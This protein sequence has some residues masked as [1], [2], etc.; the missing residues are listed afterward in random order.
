MQS[1]GP[2]LRMTQILGVLTR[3]SV[4]LAADRRLTEIGTG[5]VV[6]DDT[7]KIVSLCNA[8]GIAYTGL[9]RLD[10][11]P[12]HEWICHR[13]ADAVVRRAAE[14]IPVITESATQSFMKLPTRNLYPHTFL[15]AGYESFLHA[16]VKP[17]F[18]LITNMR[19]S[20]GETLQS[21]APT[22]IAFQFVL[23]A[24]QRIH[25]VAAGARL[26][27]SRHAALVRNMG[28]A[29]SRNTS[30]EALL[31]LMTETIVQTS[32]RPT[33]AVGERVLTMSIPKDS[34]DPTS[35]MSV[36]L[37]APATTDAATFGYLVPGASRVLQYGPSF[38]CG[39]HAV[40]DIV[41][42]DDPSRDLQSVSVRI[43][44]LPKRLD[45]HGERIAATDGA[46]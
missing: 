23:P 8:A 28:R 25:S 32:R 37:A 10:G 33:M 40:T 19:N 44:R 43:L 46:D 45:G 11:I 20:S 34:V 27:S 29:Y 5:R 9:A 18:A 36:M 42:Q 13:L 6:H 39:D 17:M 41:T 14:A 22:F 31:R 3:R 16:G 15:L 21:P 26:S 35:R 30:D 1:L 2:E 24:Q 38:V 7:C 12:T 4:L